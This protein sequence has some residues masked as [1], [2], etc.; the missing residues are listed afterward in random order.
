[1]NFTPKAIISNSARVKTVSLKTALNI[2]SKSMPAS[3][4]KSTS[5]SALPTSMLE[6]LAALTVHKKPSDPVGALNI[7]S[8]QNNIARVRTTER[9]QRK[10]KPAKDVGCNM[11]MKKFKTV[12]DMQAHFAAVH[13][14][15]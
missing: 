6:K 10:T 13:I 12:P 4:S 3:V 2:S 5:D 1:M 7:R 8:E 14:K 15:I 11:C 9:G